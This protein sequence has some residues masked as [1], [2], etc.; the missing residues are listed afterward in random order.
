MNC[1]DNNK[2]RPPPIAIQQRQNVMNF[3]S[4]FIYNFLKNIPPSNAVL[5]HFEGGFNWVYGSGISPSPCKGVTVLVTPSIAWDE[6]SAHP[7]A[8]RPVICK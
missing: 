3:F 5:R 2:A 8:F 6:K 1:S 4:Y 7:W